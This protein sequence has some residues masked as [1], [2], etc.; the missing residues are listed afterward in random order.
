MR[1]TALIWTLTACRWSR[2]MTIIFC[3]EMWN[4]RRIGTMANE[5]TVRVE[6]PV[7][8]A[9]SWNKG[10]VQKNLDELLAAYTGRVY[11]P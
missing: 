11:T 6:R 10:E 7:I 1:C 2:Q 8:P 3:R 9:M 4:P 5:L